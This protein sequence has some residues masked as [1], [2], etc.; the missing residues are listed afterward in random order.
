MTTVPVRVSE[1]LP[2][3]IVTVPVAVDS[4]TV[5]AVP[6]G[7]PLMSLKVTNAVKVA[8]VKSGHNVKPEVLKVKLPTVLV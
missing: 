1:T 8:H 3:E 4:P 5:V 2:A 6:T 7:T